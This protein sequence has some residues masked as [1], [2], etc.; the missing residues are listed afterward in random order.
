MGAESSTT[1]SILKTVYV[2]PVESVIPKNQVYRNKIKFDDKAKTGED[3][4]GAIMLRR[5]QGFTVAG[6]ALRNTAFALNGAREGLTKKVK[7]VPS[8]CV[9]EENIATGLMASAT[10]SENSFDPQL[11]LIFQSVVESHD[12]RFEV[13]TIYGGASIGTG[14]TNTGL[15]PNGIHQISKATWSPGLMGPIE[16]SL[17]DVYSDAALTVKLNTD[18]PAV[19]SS[20]DIDTRTLGVAYASGADW[21]R[22]EAAKAALYFTFYQA[23][24]STALGVD[25]LLVLSAAGGTVFDLNTSLYAYA[26]ASTYSAAGALTFTKLANAV[27]GPASKG[28]MG[29]MD[30]VTNIYAWTDMM[31]DQAALRQYVGNYGGTFEN[32]AD[33]L[34]YHGPN[35][36]K[37]TI[38]CDPVMKSG[39]SHI[40]SWEDWRTVGATMPTYKLQNSKGPDGNDMFF[41]N[42]PGNNGFGIRRYSQT[43]VYCRRLARQAKITGIVNS[44][45]PPGGGT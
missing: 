9:L 4:V 21:T 16:N 44:S 22:V 27:T 13:D 42:L 17:L 33:E 29:D 43:G 45:G 31:N 35:G 20:V 2:D 25:P 38:Q 5:P 1:Q 23:V 14:N 11:A 26:S 40:L 3:Y 36:G 19:L 15:T 28:G 30:V 8:E 37:L 39:E 32:G 18:G 7:V 24:G 34:V 12:H 10:A 6:G 41:H